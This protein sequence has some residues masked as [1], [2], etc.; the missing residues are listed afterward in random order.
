VRVDHGDLVLADDDG[1]VVV[2]SAVAEEVLGLA[3]EKVAAE[4]VVRDKLRAGAS[5]RD[6]FT[7]H[8]VL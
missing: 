5:V 6:V 1:I 8:G 2:P 4:D 3:E 7:E